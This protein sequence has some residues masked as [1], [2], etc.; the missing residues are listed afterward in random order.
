MKNKIDWRVLCTGIICLTGL[1]IYALRQGINGVLFT[2]VIGIIALALGIT[3][4]NP[5]NKK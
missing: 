5:F 3:I 4:E 2:T 1:E